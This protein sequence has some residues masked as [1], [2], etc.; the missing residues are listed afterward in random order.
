M[1]STQPE[2]QTQS[3]TQSDAP[4][5]T[6]PGSEPDPALADLRLGNAEPHQVFRWK[7]DAPLAPI[8]RDILPEIRELKSGAD[9]I[10]VAAMLCI[11]YT[12]ETEQQAPD[13][14]G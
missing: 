3:E 12:I 2:A 11:V 14:V 5:R 9:R 13:R 8:E 7:I 4:P 10:R 6:M 1:T